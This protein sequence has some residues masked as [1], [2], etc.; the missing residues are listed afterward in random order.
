[1]DKAYLK[2]KIKFNTELLRGY[3]LLLVLIGTGVTTLFVSKSFL[4]SEFDK[5]ILIFGF[6]TLIVTFF[7][8]MLLKYKIKKFIKE[9]KQ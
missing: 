6:C 7:I 9:L 5:D 1:M 8:I 2:E 4:T 3:F